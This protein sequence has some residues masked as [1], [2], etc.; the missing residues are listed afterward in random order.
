MTL[1]PC[2]EYIL[3]FL[4]VFLKRGR[5]RGMGEE[6]ENQRRAIF[7]KEPQRISRT[8]KHVH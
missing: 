8:E 4:N 7:K 1:P 3:I 6:E 5:G 2:N